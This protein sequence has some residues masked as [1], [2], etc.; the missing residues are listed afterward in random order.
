MIIKR[1]T[2][3]VTLIA[4]L[5]L[6]CSCSSSPELQSNYY[7]L[8]QP[9]LIENVEHNIITNNGMKGKLL[10]TLSLADYLKQPNIVLQKEDKS[11]YYAHSHLWAEPLEGAVIKAIMSDFNN[12]NSNSILVVN[13]QEEPLD[14]LHIQIDYFHVSELSEVI[15]AGSFSLISMSEHSLVTHK[16]FYLKDKL[17]ADG[18]GHSIV[19]MRGLLNELTHKLKVD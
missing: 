1:Q 7:L 18:Y 3:I 4:S 17:E 19:K 2:K 15:L 9:E 11:I 6:L 16:K 10:L 12:M 13:S 14:E 8:S 5:V